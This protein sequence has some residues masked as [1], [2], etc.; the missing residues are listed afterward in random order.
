MRVA[1]TGLGVVSAIGNDKESFWESLVYGR[2][3]FRE[4][5]LVDTSVLSFTTGAEVTG[6]D[7]DAGFDEGSREALD[8]FAR[9]W[10]LAAREA[11]ADSGLGFELLTDAAVVT[12]S[13]LGGQTSQDELF[14]QLY[15]EGRRRLSPFA[16]PRSMANAAASQ[17]SMEMA[18]E[19]PALT[20][21]TACASAA[22]ALGLAYWMISRGMIE[23]AIAG[24]SEAPF[25]LGH[26]KAWDS[27]RVM[28]PD[29]CRPFSKGRKGIILGEG[30]G[31]LVLE[32]LELA[33][34]RR[35]RVHA[36]LVGFGMSSDA[37]HI[38]KPSA[39]GAARAMRG[40]LDDA[41]IDPDLVGYVNAHGTGTQLN[42]VTETRAIREVFGAHADRLL[43]SSTKSM[44]GHALGA[45][46]A[47]EAVAT[48]L[49]LERGVVPPTANYLERD[50]DCP[51]DFVPNEARH[52][53]VPH[54]LSSSFAFGGLNAV[55]AFARWDG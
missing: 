31:A 3:G 51:L 38:T 32:S 35:A 48:V 13:S 55:L 23:R 11:V 20:L 50:P 27:L 17:L 19:G 53:I 45:S 5:S 34:E 24:G 41:G 10:L 52:L 16:V 46:G 42:D 28:A 39:R 8:R 12:G 54:A 29:L 43:V 21:S 33:L 40:A 30:G 1:V 26:L 25:S 36:E 47:L 37:F 15:R 6:L 49:A 9:F 18:I 22:H 44:H 7:L 2:H 4:L 14:R